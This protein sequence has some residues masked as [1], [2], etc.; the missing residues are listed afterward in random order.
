LRE[1]CKHKCV[2][3]V[4]L[5][6][7]DEVM[8]YKDIWPFVISSKMVIEVSKKYMRKMAVGFDDPRVKVNLGDGAAYMREKVGE[9]DVIIV[10]SSDPVG[11]SP[12]IIN[13]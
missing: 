12:V 6:E 3:E 1:V 8:S 2:K 5:C 7:I 4:T 13:I 9:F 11:N 10:D